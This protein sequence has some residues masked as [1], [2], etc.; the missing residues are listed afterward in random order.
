MAPAVRKTLED[1][2]RDAVNCTGEQAAAWLVQMER[3]GRYVPD[4]FA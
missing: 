4:V 3:A 2:Y 1:I